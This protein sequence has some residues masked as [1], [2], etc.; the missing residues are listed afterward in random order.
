MTPPRISPHRLGTIAFARWEARRERVAESIRRQA[1]ADRRATTGI[2][3]AIV[4]VVGDYWAEHKA[5]PST[6]DV[7]RLL[8]KRTGVPFG[9]YR[10]VWM[11]RLR[12][13]RAAG[14]L[15]HR[16]IHGW[17]VAEETGS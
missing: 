13:L 16:P 4:S 3:I 15:I 14:I 17:A 2:Y 10:K 8:G 1:E 7:V 9:S 12:K 6:E 11:E 5:G